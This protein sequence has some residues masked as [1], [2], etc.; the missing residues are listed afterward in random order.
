MSSEQGDRVVLIA[1]L[2]TFCASVAAGTV[3]GG[4]EV[5]GALYDLN[6]S[7]IENRLLIDVST[8]LETTVIHITLAT[9]LAYLVGFGVH[10]AM[11]PKKK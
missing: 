7:I 6:S 8:A 10:Q 11:K 3:W 4:P 2:S 5:N 9:V 1:M